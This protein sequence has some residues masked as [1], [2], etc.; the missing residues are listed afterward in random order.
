[1]YPEVAEQTQGLKRFLETVLPHTLGDVERTLGRPVACLP[2]STYA[3]PLCQ[4]R[5]VGFGGFGFPKIRT[6]FYSVDTAGGLQVWYRDSTTVA[7]TAV[8]L[9]VDSSFTPFNRQTQ[10]NFGTRFSWD[11]DHL[12]VLEQALQRRFGRLPPDRVLQPSAPRD[13]QR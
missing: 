2:D 1:M 11:R 10:N 9:R 12:A 5:M 4:T 7:V 6:E 13:G 3:M 8:Y